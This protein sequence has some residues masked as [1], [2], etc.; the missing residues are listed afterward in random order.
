MAGYETHEH[1]VLLIGAGGAGLRAAI[2]ASA[3]VCACREARQYVDANRFDNI[4]SVDVPGG[5]DHPQKSKLG[6]AAKNYP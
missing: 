3:L 6:K 5:P 2:A 1:D 4:R